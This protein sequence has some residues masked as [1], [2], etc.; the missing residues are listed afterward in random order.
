MKF[1]VGTQYHRPPTPK[2]EHWEADFKL[3]AEKGFNIARAWA[4]WSW[5]NPKEGT[6]DFSEMERMCELGQKNGIGIILL[7]NIESCP[8][9]LYK[10]FPHTTYVA[11]TGKPAIPHT[12]HNTCVGGFPGLCTDHPEI[13]ERAVEYIA[14]LVKRF[15]G[16]PAMHGWEPHNEPLI[17][18]ARYNHEVFCYCPATQGR[19]RQWLRNKYGTIEA[20]NNAWQRRWSDFDEIIAPTELGSF[21]DWTDWRLFAIESLVEQDRWRIQTIRDNDGGHPV[22][23]HSR[24]GGDRRDIVCDGT[25]DWRLAKLADKFGYANFPQGKT[26]FEHALSGDICRS[27]AQGKEF[28]MHELQSGPFGIGLQRNNPFFVILGKGGATDVDVAARPDEVGAVTGQRIAQWSWLSLSQGAKGLLFWQFRTEQWGAEYGFNLVNLDGTAT[29]R[30]DMAGRIATCIRENEDLFYA[31]KPPQ[32]QVAIGFSPMNPML[33]YFADGNLN[34]Y[35]ACYLGTNR[36]LAHS[37]H[38]IDVVRMDDQ[39]VD[40]DFSKYKA[41]FYPLP[42]WLD[43]KTAGK[44]KRFVENGGLLVAEPSLGQYGTDYFSVDTVPGMGL[45]EIFG[46]RR[47]IISTRQSVP[48]KYKAK[49]LP[50]RFLEEILIPRGAKVIGKYADGSPA[51]T[52][53]EYGKGKAV[54]LGT[55][56]FMEYIF[57]ESPATRGFVAD[58]T[59]TLTRWATVS[60]PTETMVKYME[61]PGKKLV[62][63]I[64]CFNKNQR[65]VLTLASKVKSARDIFNGGTVKFTPQGGKSSAAFSLKPYDTRLLLVEE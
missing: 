58:L 50:S 14:A 9:W 46:C 21:A 6:Y 25:D 28:W 38:P 51:I 64:N 27:A 20:V 19:F 49:T 5:L 31:L 22:L 18:P 35:L 41:I 42:L 63:L 8:G 33:T 65:T 44:L 60:V 17:E 53:N 26:P 45:D 37:G 32:A 12:V 4:M 48:V 40:D 59:K 11:R 1:P 29:E 62:F 54:Y 24:G 7:V 34:A 16:H 47:E 2:A 61:C 13:K 3:M 43:E 15:A 52:M 56:L 39:A 30:L 10:K 36:L 57:S 23:M 55:N